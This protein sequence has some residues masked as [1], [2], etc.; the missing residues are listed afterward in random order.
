MKKLSM[1]LSAF[2]AFAMASCGNSGETSNAADSAQVSETEVVEETLT[3]TP[4]DSSA[5]A[6]VEDAV[7]ELKGDEQ[8]VPT[9]K[10]MV[11]DFNATWCGPCKQFAPTYHKVAGEYA[12]KAVFTS[13][14]VDVCEALANKYNIKNIPCVVI[15]YPESAKREAVNTIGNLSEKEF[16]EFLDKNL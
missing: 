13:A 8:A 4:T 7:I 10:P 5:T 14:D 9:D 1:I 11:I 6:A 12:D 2:V 15:V 16:K 3:V